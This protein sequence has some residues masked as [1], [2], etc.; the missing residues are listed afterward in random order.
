MT[1]DHAIL[2]QGDR[3]FLTDKFN[4]VNPFL[5]E[6]ELKISLT[7]NPPPYYLILNL[8][9]TG[10]DGLEILKYINYSELT[11]KTLILTMYNESSL[12]EK[13]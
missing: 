4:T 2:A 7:I 11:I 8:N 6:M 5:D 13:C 12:I 10:L 3:Q 9:L 1:E